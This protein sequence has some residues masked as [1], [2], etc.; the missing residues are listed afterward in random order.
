ME[1][2]I[3]PLGISTSCM[4]FGSSGRVPKLILVIAG[5]TLLAACKHDFEAPHMGCISPPFFV[6]PPTLPGSLARNSRQV[7]AT[8]SSTEHELAANFSCWL[9][10]RGCQGIGSS[11]RIGRSNL[12]GWGLFAARRIRPGEAVLSLPLRTL[13]LSEESVDLS[14][15]RAHLEDVSETIW[16]L[17]GFGNDTPH[18]DPLIAAQL[19][20]HEQKG[21]KS[22]WAPYMAM[23]PRKMRAGWRWKSDQVCSL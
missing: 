20:L 17:Y 3:A 5:A 6:S 4:S 9:S 18:G 10:D 15:H 14:P 13:S 12:G 22:E 7:T 16:S 21:L 2:M 23:L 11:V 8:K 19:L 1:A